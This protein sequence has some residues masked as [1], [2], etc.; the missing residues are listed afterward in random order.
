MN[1]DTLIVRVHLDNDQNAIL[2]ED[3]VD[4]HIFNEPQS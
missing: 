1:S 3:E 2:S 4:Q